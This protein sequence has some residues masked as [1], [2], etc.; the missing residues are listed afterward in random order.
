[1]ALGLQTVGEMAVWLTWALQLPGALQC[2]R[3]PGP[4]SLI[5]QETLS[6]PLIHPGPQSDLC[7]V[8]G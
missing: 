3:G 8:Q 5:S 1:M 6:R 4:E 7:L 2:T